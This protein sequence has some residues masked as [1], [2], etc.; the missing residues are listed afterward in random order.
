MTTE[1][2]TN[3][4]DKVTG[5]NFIPNVY[6][7]EEYREYGILVFNN[8]IEPDIFYWKGQQIGCFDA[9][10]IAE[11]INDNGRQPDS[12][13]EAEAFHYA[14]EHSRKKK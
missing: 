2:K 5:G 8:I 12:L 14:K 7:N 6:S 9:E 13:D 3:E 1:L 4:L 11:F 10:H